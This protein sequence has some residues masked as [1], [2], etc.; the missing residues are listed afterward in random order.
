M[1]IELIVESAGRLFESRAPLGRSSGDWPGDLWRE[2]EESGYPLA[3]LSED[4]GGFG[5]STEEALAMVRVAAASA[6]PLPVGETMLANWLLVRAGSHPL[7]GALTLAEETREG[8]V[9][10]PFGRYAAAVLAFSDQGGSQDRLSVYCPPAQAWRHEFSV[11]GEARDS[12]GVE[13]LGPPR[14]TMPSPV[15][16][17]VFRALGTVVRAVQ[18][19]GAI[20]RTLELALQYTGSREQFGRALA[21]FQ[22]IQHQLAVMAAQTAAARTAA[23]MAAEALSLALSAPARFLVLA[24]SSKIRAADAATAVAA[25]VHQ[26]HVSFVWSEE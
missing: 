9:R 15:D 4:D 24:A 22:V 21:K 17:Q 26:M 25:A 6:V 5:F 2:I 16:R 11:A 8:L 7:Q 10:V 20:E 19:A 1:Q 23:D 3:L 13:A 18:M 14:A 12:S